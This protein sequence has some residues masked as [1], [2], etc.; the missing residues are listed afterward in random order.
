MISLQ[1]PHTEHDPDAPRLAVLHDG[2]GL[3]RDVGFERPAGAAFVVPY[4]LDDLG[5]L[6]LL[7][8]VGALTVL[9]A[10]AGRPLKILNYGNHQEIA[11]REYKSFVESLQKKNPTQAQ[12]K[13]KTDDI[14]DLFLENEYKSEANY[15][16][17]SI[18]SSTTITTTTTTSNSSTTTET[19]QE[20]TVESWES[21][22]FDDM[23]EL[24]AWMDE[25]MASMGSILGDWG[26]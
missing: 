22:D 2:E 3:V 26:F 24:E 14:W 7:G 17:K 5:L 16:K 23:E 21:S 15:Y 6:P 10:G 11:E 18:C 13:L 1:I 8:K 4:S 20:S 19:K 9:S 25:I 12:D